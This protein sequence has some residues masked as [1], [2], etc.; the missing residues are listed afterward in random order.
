LPAGV[1][2]QG[3]NEGSASQGNFYPY[4]GDVWEVNALAAGESATLTV[5]Y[6][7]LA[8]ND[9]VSLY[10][11]VTEQDGTDTD[12]AAGNGSCCTANEDDEAAFIL[13]TSSNQPL[14]S[15]HNANHTL[16][17]AA[18]LIEK[19]YPNPTADLLN[20]ELESSEES[21]AFL[22]IVNVSG[23]SFLQKEMTIEKGQTALKMEVQDL[24]RGV[25]FLKIETESGVVIER[26][27]K[28]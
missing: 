21:A 16:A 22:Q 7:V 23:Q 26:F 10:G 20:V 1:Q 24:P 3:G 15:N 19:V 28:Q 27:L 14:I 18:F 13:T 25:Y 6:F 8:A 5:N 17:N 12:S 11:Q 9:P 4:G 2:Y